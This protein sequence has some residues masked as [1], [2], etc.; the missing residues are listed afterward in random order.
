MILVQTLV[1]KGCMSDTAIIV[2]EHEKNV[3]LENILWY[4][5]LSKK[6][7]IWRYGYLYLSLP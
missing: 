4:F 6:R 2:C 7:N 1:D 3:T 5:E